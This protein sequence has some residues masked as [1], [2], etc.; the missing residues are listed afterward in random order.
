MLQLHVSVDQAKDW[1]DYVA[2]VATAF[3]ALAAIGTVAVALRISNNQNRLQTML[4]DRQLDMQERQL[5]KDL[6]DRRFAIFTDTLEFIG[7]VLR[8]DGNIVLEGQEYRHFREAMQKAGMLFGTDVR[9][10]LNGLDKTARDL[11]VS[12]QGRGQAVQSSDVEAIK[13]HSELLSHV[14]ELA[15]AAEDVFRSYLSL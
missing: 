6:F 12:A 15:P 13:K 4:A 10:Y 8:N 5:K 7:L 11:Y 9:N 3:G 14:I 2:P 1:L